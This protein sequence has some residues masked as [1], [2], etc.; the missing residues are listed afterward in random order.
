[1]VSVDFSYS[2]RDPLCRFGMTPLVEVGSALVD[3]VTHFVHVV[4]H[5]VDSV[6]HFVDMEWWN[7]ESQILSRHILCQ[8]PDCWFGPWPES[9]KFV[10]TRSRINKSGQYK[11]RINNSCHHVYCDIFTYNV[12][13]LLSLCHHLLIRVNSRIY[14]LNGWPILLARFEAKKIKTKRGGRG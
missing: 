11:S 8:R 3:S 10:I 12:L 9:T 5:F 2:W 1:M 7:G 13:F 6:T 14:N 4:T